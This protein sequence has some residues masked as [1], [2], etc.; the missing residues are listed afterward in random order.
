MDMSH[1]NDNLGFYVKK[2]LFL[3]YKI[4]V[5]VRPAQKPIKFYS[6]CLESNVL[7]EVGACLENNV[8]ILHL[9]LCSIFCRTK[10]L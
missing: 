4:H 9:F 5:F 10:A 7:V 6:L 1:C 8:Q 2:I 3:L